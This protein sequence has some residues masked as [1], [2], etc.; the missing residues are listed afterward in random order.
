MV[1]NFGTY[2]V[3]L[4][5][6]YCFLFYYVT[7]LNEEYIRARSFLL[8]SHIAI[9]IVLLACTKVDHQHQ[10]WSLMKIDRYCTII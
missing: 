10:F 1:V 9:C 8:V 7:F 5:I 2:Y 4:V 6:N 3:S